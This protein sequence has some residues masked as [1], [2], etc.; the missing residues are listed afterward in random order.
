M[1]QYMKLR[2]AFVLSMGIRVAY[3]DFEGGRVWLLYIDV[4]WFFEIFVFTTLCIFDVS[5]RSM[6]LI[7]VII[8]FH[9]D[10]MNYVFGMI[11]ALFAS[12]MI[13]SYMLSLGHFGICTSSL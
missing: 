10:D 9:I 13:V 7:S 6:W 1:N 5:C 8:G 3:Y 4:P 2:I 12:P 11:G